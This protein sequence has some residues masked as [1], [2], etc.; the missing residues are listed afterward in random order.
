MRLLPRIKTR[1]SC[2]DCR[3]AFAR[4]LIRLRDAVSILTLCVCLVC[5]CSYEP[6]NTPAFSDNSD[7]KR[8]D[9]NNGPF[10][11]ELQQAEAQDGN[12]PEPTHLIKWK[13]TRVTGSLAQDR[14]LSVKYKAYYFHMFSQPAVEVEMPGG[15]KCTALLDS[16][17]PGAVY[18]N[19]LIVRRSDLAVFPLGEH[20]DTGCAQGFCEIPS[21]I[22]GTVTVENPPCWYEQRHW[23]LK[24]LGVPLY[25]HETLLIG[26]NM[27]SKFSYVLFDN[28]KRRVTFSPHDEFEAVAPSEWVGIPFVLERVQGASRLMVDISMGGHDARV[29]FDTCGG[30]PGLILR[31]DTW[32]RAAQS[33]QARAR[34]KA[35]DPSF[36]F[37]WR[38]S[39]RYVL[40]ELQIGRLN[41]KNTKVNVLPADDKLM[42]NLEG[43]ITL[44]CF[45]KTAAVLDFKKNLLWI[46]KF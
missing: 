16:G 31:Q 38:W 1:M 32:Q 21:I 8:I 26:L 44:D 43:I 34:G 15:Q 36:Q 2:S 5:A 28:M 7:A 10:V 13:Q 41:L 12:E 30:K 14:S 23:Q 29:E 19:D 25:R 37:G 40:P 45:K 27:M 6:A 11:I 33:V 18:V 3:L 20:P 42:R 46:K 35:L 4:M 9:P 39:R 24:V 17:Y 22:I